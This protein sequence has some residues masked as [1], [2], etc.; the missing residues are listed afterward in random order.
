MLRDNTPNLANC[1][2]GAE[3]VHICVT[4]AFLCHIPDLPLFENIANRFGV[5]TCHLPLMDVKAI[6]ELW[7]VGVVKI[8]LFKSGTQYKSKFI[9]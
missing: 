4:P 1:I 5:K 9:F 7:G 6:P 3:L 2:Y 8:A